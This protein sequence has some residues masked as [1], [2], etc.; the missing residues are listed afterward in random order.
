MDESLLVSRVLSAAC[1]MRPGGDGSQG[2]MTW[3]TAHGSPR[4]FPYC[5]DN[6]MLY[7]IISLFNMPHVDI[8]MICFG[9]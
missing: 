9:S 4:T 7:V 8:L 3:T 5:T 2:G 1:T 6:E